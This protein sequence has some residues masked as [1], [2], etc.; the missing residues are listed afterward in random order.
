MPTDYISIFHNT[1]P[2]LIQLAQQPCRT[3]KPLYISYIN[4][5]LHRYYPYSLLPFCFE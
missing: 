5:Q 2:Q 1:N 3:P 4:H